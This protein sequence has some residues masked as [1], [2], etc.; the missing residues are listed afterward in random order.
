MGDTMVMKSPILSNRMA[1]ES[2]AQDD[3]RYDVLKRGNLYEQIGVLYDMY[4]A[5]DL[6]LSDSSE[7][8][9]TIA[10]IESFDGKPSL[11]W[12]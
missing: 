12:L 8:G 4:N 3:L 5:A 10:D 9:L 7:R 6:E 2:D 11:E 1:E